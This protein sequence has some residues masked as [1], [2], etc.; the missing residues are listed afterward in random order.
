[1]GLL[2]DDEKKTLKRVSLYVQS[3]SLDLGWI[4]LSEGEYDED[5]VFDRTTC[6]IFNNTNNL[7]IPEPYY[8]IIQKIYDYSFS[9]GLIEDK[10][11]YDAL[12]QTV[13]ISLYTEERKIE[14][15]YTW[16]ETEQDDVVTKLWELDSD[17]NDDEELSQIFD[18]LKDIGPRELVLNFNGSGDEG[19]VD[20]V[21]RQNYEEVPEFFH[22]WCE[23]Q[24]SNNFGDWGDNDGSSGSFVV[25]F[26]EKTIKLHFY[27]NIIGDRSIIIFSENF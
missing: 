2:T 6:P 8:P 5:T 12:F 26:D 23:E 9:T 3:S 18:M 17:D 27:R 24:L 14:L 15:E 13:E 25:N 22:E 19:Y 11:D 21:F 16:G 10:D 4:R 1:M 7:E 20:D